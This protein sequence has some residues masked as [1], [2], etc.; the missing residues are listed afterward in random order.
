MCLRDKRSGVTEMLV[1][2]EALGFGKRLVR[3]GQGV[4]V[5]VSFNVA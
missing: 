3:R 4:S 2:G 1:G 5:G